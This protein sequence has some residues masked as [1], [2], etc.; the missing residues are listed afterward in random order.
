MKA[1]P[2]CAPPLPGS[3]RHIHRLQIHLLLARVNLTGAV[4]TGL[5]RAGKAL[6]KHF[7]GRQGGLP[8]W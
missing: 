4:Y 3:H 6:H 7:A 1:Y 8:C 2:A 5:Q